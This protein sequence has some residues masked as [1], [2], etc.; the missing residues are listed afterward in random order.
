MRILFCTL[1][2]EVA[3]WIAAVTLMWSPS[4]Q[5]LP[6]KLS[7]HDWVSSEYAALTLLLFASAVLLIL[8]VDCSLLFFFYPSLDFS[9]ATLGRKTRASMIRPLGSYIPSPFNQD[10]C[11]DISQ[12]VGVV[13]RE[14]GPNPNIVGQGVSG[15]QKT[16]RTDSRVFDF[17]HAFSLFDSIS[18]QRSV[19]SHKCFSQWDNAWGSRAGRMQ[20]EYCGLHLNIYLFCFLVPRPISLCLLL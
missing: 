12:R 11:L 19:A 20:A 9:K 1:K 15:S 10:S 8:F 14:C 5:P 13:P 2:P 6:I 7:Q 3:L 4:F 16:Q 17:E 18:L